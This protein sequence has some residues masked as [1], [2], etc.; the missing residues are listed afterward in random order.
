[1]GSAVKAKDLVE[2]HPVLALSACDTWTIATLEANHPLLLS[3]ITALP[4][5]P[6]THHQSRHL[7]VV[8]GGQFPN[9]LRP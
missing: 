6:L 5:P 9:I 4:Y 1:V 8:S 2:W 7:G 3:N